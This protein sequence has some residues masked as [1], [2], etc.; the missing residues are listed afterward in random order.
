MT[1]SEEMREEQRKA[2]EARPFIVAELRS[3]RELLDV[4]STVSERW[5]IDERKAYRWVHYVS[6]E[7][8]TRKKRWVVLG[9]ISVWLGVLVALAGTALSLF[10]TIMVVAEPW[11]LGLA[12]GAPLIVIG[13]TLIARSAQLVRLSV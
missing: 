10:A 3:D 4:A 8:A 6:E 2:N 12:V 13:A 9:L 11:V 7:F 5:T 1:K